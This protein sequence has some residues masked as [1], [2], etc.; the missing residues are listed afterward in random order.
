[1]ARRSK[2][3]EIVAKILKLYG[4]RG[5]QGSSMRGGKK[6]LEQMIDAD[7]GAQVSGGLV[8]DA[9]VGPFGVAKI[10]IIKLARE[11]RLPLI[12]IMCWT[13]RKSCLIVGTK[14]F[15]HCSSL[16]SFSSVNAPFSCHATPQMNRWRRYGPNL[17][18]ISVECAERRRNTLTIGSVPI[19]GLSRDERWAWSFRK[20]RT[21]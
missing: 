1:M 8:A 4:L 20:D 2:D 7:N 14:L 11:T 15:C 10:G 12:P 18:T 17:R 21:F 19:L 5:A 13:K 16:I 9:P 6:A 3:G